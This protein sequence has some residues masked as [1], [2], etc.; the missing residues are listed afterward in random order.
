MI[1]RRHITVG[2]ISGLTAVTALSWLGLQELSSGQSNAAQSG[3]IAPAASPSSVQLSATTSMP[4]GMSMPGS[5]T[6]NST[7][8]ASAASGTGPATLSS[9]TIPKMGNVI[10]DK[11]GF[12]LYRFDK[13]SAKPPTSNCADK[14][15]MIWP[16][17][18]TNGTPTITGV[19][20]ALVGAVARPDG[21]TQVTLN[22]WPLY[23]F[24]NDPTPGAWKGQAVGGTWWV[25]DQNGKKNLTCVPKTPPP[26]PTMPPMT[27]S[28]PM[29]SMPGMP[30]GGGA[31]T[32]AM[33]GMPGM[34]NGY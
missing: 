8:S 31:S 14:C 9:T 2:I 12:V 17:V 21:T 20:P 29:P 28:A 4:P 6:P 27:S 16:P 15:A 24:S 23:R 30:A 19:N 34:G 22:G 3:P 10:E 25:I 13:D 7:N 18:L 32:S 26:A 1:S 11:D 5:S 33:P